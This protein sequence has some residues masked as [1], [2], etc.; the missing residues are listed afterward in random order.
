VNAMKTW[1]AGLAAFLLAFG[2]AWAQ[3]DD[4]FRP[5]KGKEEEELTPEQAMK[6]L[7]EAQ[8][9]M[10]RCEELLNDSSRGKALE[11]E[12]ELLKKLA[13]L[14]KEEEKKDPELVQKRILEMIQRMLQKTE[15]KQQDTIEKLN[16]IIK[17]AKT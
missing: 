1:T 10:L 15:K 8:E 12:S 4:K 16:E 6:M 9:L 14:L 13:E 7:Q 3:D 11:A 2:A 17:R 5:E